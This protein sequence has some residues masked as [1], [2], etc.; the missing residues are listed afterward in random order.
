MSGNGIRLQK[1][2]VE[3]IQIFRGGGREIGFGGKVFE[4][5]KQI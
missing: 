5:H 1:Q 3:E 2:E 4:F